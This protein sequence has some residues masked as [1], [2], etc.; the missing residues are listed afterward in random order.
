MSKIQIKDVEGLESA[1]TSKV[2]KNLF[3]DLSDE[4]FKISHRRKLESLNPKILVNKNLLDKLLSQK[5]DKVRGKGLSK[6]DFTDSLKE[7]LDSLT[8]LD[9]HQLMQ[10]ILSDPEVSRLF[11]NSLFEIIRIENG[12]KDLSTNDFTNELKQKLERLSVSGSSSG[13]SG[14][15]VEQLLQNSLF[16]R[17]VNQSFS[18]GIKNYVR[19]VFN[20]QT[21]TLY[22]STNDDGKTIFVNGGTEIVFTLN[23][24]VNPLSVITFQKVTS[25]NVTFRVNVS[26]TLQMTLVDGTNVISGAVGSTATLSFFD[27]NNIFLR[28]SNA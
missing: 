23:E 12:G 27:E 26:P 9:S 5:V 13:S 8:V 7:K 10:L 19:P 21:G 14:L 16:R 15:T 17:Y 4:N 18:D 25:G 28:I 20:S 22:F 24:Y 11:A 1:L 6:N 2:D 3:K